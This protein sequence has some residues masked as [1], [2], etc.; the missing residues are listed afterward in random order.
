MNRP[1]T[2]SFAATAF[3]F[4]A[5]AHAQYYDIIDLGTLGGDASGGDGMNE[6]GQ[7]VGWSKDAPGNYF[8][9]ISAPGGP[10]LST[11][12]P[13]PNGDYTY[14]QGINDL[15]EVVG[16][17]EMN[18][19]FGQE[20]RA[21]LWRNNT[22]TELGVL[23]GGLAS[24]AYDINN[25]GQVVGWSETDV[26]ALWAFVWENGVMSALPSL[27]DGYPESSARGINQN[28]IVVG[29]QWD[30]AISRQAVR[31]DLGAGTVTV[32]P[33]PA[34]A[35]AATGMD[36][37]EHNITV[38]NVWKPGN[39]TQAVM[40]DAAG[41]PTLL[42]YVRTHR[43][44][45]AY[46]INNDGWSVGG[47]YS[48]G[49]LLGGT[50]AAALW[51]D[52]EVYDLVDLSDAVSAGWHFPYAYEINDAGQ[53]SGTGYYG[54]FRAYLL[55]PKA[56][57]LGLAGPQ[58]GISGQDNTLRVLGATPGATVHFIY[59]LRS[60]SAAVPGCPG[61]FVD[62]RNPII[63]GTATADGSGRAALTV[64]IPPA[65]QHETVLV[66]AVERGSCRVS[67]VSST[68]IQ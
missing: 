40:W 55:S 9:F 2:L 61:L 43:S 14:A 52:G 30:S 25:A 4:A 37:N 11:I 7:T 57:G 34:G 53:I 39:L 59:S 58:P 68:F 33:M 63:A 19:G 31:W 56:D 64:A 50:S 23:A 8:A 48:G 20:D 60:G 42:P 6:L 5:T 28:G 67:G 46:G 62:L 45:V 13:M 54:G 29:Y 38:G 16:F 51:I 41:N 15:G 1:L 65:A 24:Q 26:A 66:Q 27:P 47:T 35:V 22:I 21:F 36:I 17:G 32:L 12:G 3:L 18:V 49:H 44:G 10:P